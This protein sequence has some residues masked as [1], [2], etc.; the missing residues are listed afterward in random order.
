MHEVTSGRIKNSKII[1]FPPT[2][3]NIFR[4]LL[5]LC[6]SMIKIVEFRAKH[7]DGVG[8]CPLMNPIF[9]LKL[10]WIDWSMPKI[11]CDFRKQRA[12]KMKIN[13]NCYKKNSSRAP[14]NPSQCQ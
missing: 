10:I 9:S 1:N 11:W 4:I 2:C 7:M 3:V 12:S 5:Y 13:K 8:F 14:T 6:T